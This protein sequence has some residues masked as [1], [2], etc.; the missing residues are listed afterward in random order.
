VPFIPI[1]AKKKALACDWTWDETYS[2]ERYRYC[3]VCQRPVY[4]FAGIEMPEA[5][6]IILKAENLTKFTLYQRPDGKFMTG[7]CSRALKK[8]NDMI[9]MSVGGVLLVTFLLLYMV[10]LPH[11]KPR[12]QTVIAPPTVPTATTAGASRLRPNS[13]HLL[14][15]G[16]KLQPGA[17]HYDPV[18]GKM[19]V[20]VPVAPAP[21]PPVA[22]TAGPDEIEQDWEFHT[23]QK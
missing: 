21:P 19:V 2:N 13:S 22:N 20:D 14:P 9:L 4:N 7:N 23:P 3:G 10:M 1:T 15:N 8:R 16:A 5:E 17:S 18:S 12:P 6:A 11:P